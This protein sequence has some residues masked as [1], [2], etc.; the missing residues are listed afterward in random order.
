MS[1]KCSNAAVSLNF[2]SQ[3][4]LIEASVPSTMKMHG[5]K[6]IEDSLVAPLPD[7]QAVLQGGVEGQP[8]GVLGQRGS[9]LVTPR[10]L[11]S[12]ASEAHH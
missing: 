9:P 6:N 1:S 12:W 10:I 2:G 3:F 5:S 11:L 7:P 4:N 8:A